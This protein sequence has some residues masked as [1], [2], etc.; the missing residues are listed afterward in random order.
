M[1]KL[2]NYLKAHKN[3]I[4][5]GTGAVLVSALAYEYVRAEYCSMMLRQLRGYIEEAGYKEELG[6]MWW[7]DIMSE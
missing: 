6:A 7:K 2:T 5:A 3:E 4:L 1:H